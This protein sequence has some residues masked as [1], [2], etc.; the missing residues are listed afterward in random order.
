[1]PRRRAQADSDETAEETAPKPKPAAK[2]T[3]RKVATPDTGIIETKE[4]PRPEPVMPPAHREEGAPNGIIL[5]SGESLVIEGDD[6]GTYVT[7]SRDVYRKITPYNARR[8]TYILLYPRGAK[9]LKSKLEP[10]P[11]K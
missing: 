3:S 6:D 8:P 5:E 2:K 11:K 4:E 9:I 1:M 10:A 7:V